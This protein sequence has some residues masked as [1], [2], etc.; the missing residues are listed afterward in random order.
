MASHSSLSTL[1]CCLAVTVSC[2]KKPATPNIVLFLVDDLGYGDLGCYGNETVKT[3]NIDRL[4]SEGLKFTRMYS[5]SACTP[6]R[7][8]LLTGRYPIRN[9]MLKGWILPFFVLASPAQTGGLPDNE[10]TLAEMLKQSGYATGMLGKWHLGFGRGGKYL[11]TKHGFDYFYGL[12]MTHLETCEPSESRKGLASRFLFVYISFTYKLWG[13]LCVGVFLIWVFSF[14]GKRALVFLQLSVILLLLTGYYILSNFTVVGAKESC[15]LM[16]NDDIIEQPYK[17]ENMTLKLTQEALQYVSRHKNNPFF[18]LISYLTLHSPVFASRYF[19]GRSGIG[20]YGDALMELD[21]SV[22]Q[23]LQQLKKQGLEDNTMTIFL[24]DNSPSTVGLDGIPMA[25]G[26]GGS[27]GVVENSAGELVRLRGGKLNLFEGGIRIPGIIRWDGV[28]PAN[29]ESRALVSLNDIFPTVADI[30][31]I[32]ISD[33]IIDGKSL[34]PLL[35]NPTEI[36]NHHDYLL[37]YCTTKSPP[38]MIVGEYKIHYIKPFRDA[39]CTGDVL[40]S[41]IVY[42][43]SDDPGEQYPLPAE[44]TQAVRNQAREILARVQKTLP[45]SVWSEF[46]S[47]ILPWLFPCANYPYCRLEGVVKDDFDNLQL[48]KIVPKV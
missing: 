32:S 1:L 16:L 20:R 30:L 29:T 10:Y 13:G 42:D 38:A 36:S 39:V 45:E 24:S 19:E 41:P 43:L 3:P 6:S 26:V 21:W 4:A 23:V 15:I 17:A 9:G 46:D 2:A 27:T 11:P 28:I 7:A 40:Q 12:P 44:E 5:Q 34:L 35:R 31:N 22:G 14:I 8:A 25:K 47:L 18:L 33:R 37:F 48:P